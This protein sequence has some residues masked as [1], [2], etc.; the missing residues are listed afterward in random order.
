MRR[1]NRSYWSSIGLTSKGTLRFAVWFSALKNESKIDHKNA[2]FPRLF[3]ATVDKGYAPFCV[4]AMIYDK[5]LLVDYPAST[6][7]SHIVLRTY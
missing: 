6:L 3:F 5:D 2:Y 1:W 4:V 7:E